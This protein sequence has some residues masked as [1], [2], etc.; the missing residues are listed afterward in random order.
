MLLAKA[1]S[2]G[3]KLNCLFPENPSSPG[4]EEEAAGREDRE[5]KALH[6]DTARQTHAPAAVCTAHVS[7]KWRAGMQAPRGR[8]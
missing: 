3:P 5:S 6:G 2:A 8:C 4:R 7:G 1:D